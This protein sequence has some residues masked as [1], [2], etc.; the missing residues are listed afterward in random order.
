MQ[1]LALSDAFAALEELESSLGEQSLFSW[2]DE[3]DQPD[4]MSNSPLPMA[5]LP[6]AE[7]G[8][9]DLPPIPEP[10]QL[11]QTLPGTEAPKAPAPAPVQQVPPQLPYQPQAQLPIQPQARQPVQP[12]QPS[13]QPQAQLPMQP[14]ARQAQPQAQPPMQQPMGQQPMQPQVPQAA[15]PMQQ[16]MQ[17]PSQRP[18]PQPAQQ[19]QAPA[20]PPAQQPAP[21]Q[22]LQA[23]PPAQ[24][25]VQQPIEFSI[26]NTPQHP[27]LAE[28]VPLP[29]ASGPAHMA[30]PAHMSPAR[31]GFLRDITAMLSELLRNYKA[32][33]DTEAPVIT[34][35]QIRALGKKHLF[36]MI[37]DL[38]G[39]LA[40]EKA[41]K[42]NLLCAFSAGMNAGT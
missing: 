31:T 36:M 2:R 5:P 6:Q 18:A 30:G 27:P 12:I 32:P 40:Q 8:S 34:D 13:Y 15:Q 3:S 24:P 38:E 11:F 22:G 26:L 14:Q 29:R 28:V 10:F 17:P 37:R 41:E 25:P 21:Q 7:P 42:R 9:F 1:N 23:Q 19:I 39:E 20:Q 16:P 4:F 33:E 35:K